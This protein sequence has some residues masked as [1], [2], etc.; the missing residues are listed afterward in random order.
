MT[1]EI[2]KLNGKAIVKSV[3]RR[4][5]YP[6]HLY[7]LLKLHRNKA[8][9]AR[10]YDDPQLKLYGQVFLGDFLNYGHFDDPDLQP[11]AMSLNDIYR[12]QARNAELIVEL[13]TDRSSPVLDV[14]SGMGGLVRLML[15]QGLNPVALSPDRNQIEHLRSKYPQLAVLQSK[16]E[17]IPLEGNLHR[18]GTIITSESL[19]FL[20]LRLALPLMAKLLKPGGRWIACDCFRTGEERHRSSG[21]VWSDFERQV[22][23]SGWTFAFRADHT[24]NVMPTL[25]FVH[26]WGNDIALPAVRF[27]F[28][29]FRTKQPLLHYIFE[30]II[31]AM[32]KKIHKNL[33]LMAPQTYSLYTRYMLLA[34]ERTG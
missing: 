32:N 1:R 26:M 20:N 13:I 8:A 12:A 18:Y 4:S 21:H 33:D 6:R 27:G 17:D 15:N 14:G 16:F 23:A 22:L 9:T 31:A 34:M 5:L 2:E 19:Q 10:A 7:Q 28:E 3:L 30:E 29:K 11:R 25:R 24:P